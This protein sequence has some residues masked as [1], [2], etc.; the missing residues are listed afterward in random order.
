MTNGRVAFAIRASSFGFGL[1]HVLYVHQNYPAQF[2][3]VARHLV[4]LG[5]KCSFVS[6]TSEGDDGG[7]EKIAFRPSGKP[8]KEAHSCARGFEGMIWQCDGIY[9]A[10]KKRPDIK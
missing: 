3:H 8:A 1:M 6:R 7:I 9:R 4:K 10:L 2:G 5:W